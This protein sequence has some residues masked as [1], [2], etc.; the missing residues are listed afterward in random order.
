M[1]HSET[2]DEVTAADGRSLRVEAFD[3]TPDVSLPDE[4]QPKR[5]RRRTLQIVGVLA[6]VGFVLL[7]APGL[8]QV[9][10]LLTEA[11][12][13]WVALAVAFEA[14]SCLSYV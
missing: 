3:R 11:R 12:P 13:E 10:D 1:R 14:M 6:V 4:F 5:L 7:L 2:L 8:G 9:R